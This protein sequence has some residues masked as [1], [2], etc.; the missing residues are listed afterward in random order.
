M[1]YLIDRFYFDLE[2]LREQVGGY[3]LLSS[4][5][6]SMNWPERGVYFFFEAGETRDF[7]DDLRVVRVGTHAVSKGSKTT[8]WDRLRTHRGSLSG[9]YA[10]GG[11]HRGSIFRLHVG[12]AILNKEGLT[13][14]YSS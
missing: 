5:T 8:L 12:S 6:G 1:S 2:D 10:G 3:R 14:E 9:R 11:N 4:C 13:G 7:K